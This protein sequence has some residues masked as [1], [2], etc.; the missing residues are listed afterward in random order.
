MKPMIS[1]FT[2]TFALS[3]SLLTA[4][5]PLPIAAD[6]LKEKVE[7]L[8]DPAREGRAT[9]EPGAQ[10]SAEW[11][12]KYLADNGLLPVNSGSFQD[13][14]FN[15]G[16][17]LVSEK[18]FFEIAGNS[19]RFE[20]DKDFRPLSYSD[21][22]TVEGEVVFAGYGL[23]APEEQGARRY[24]SYEGVDVKDKIVL[25]LR[26]VPE[27]LEPARRAQLNRYAG[28]RYKAMLARSR[29]A[30]A[31]LVV[32]GP[33][34]PLP[35]ELLPLANDG[36]LSGSN[37]LAASISGST[38]DALLNPSGKSLKDLQTA[39]DSEN[40]HAEQ[41]FVIPDLHVKLDVELERI[42][43]TDRN[44]LAA[45]PPV[46]TDE[47][48][49]V[50][51]HYDHLGHGSG[52]NSLAHAEEHD[53]IHP[54]ADDN[55][56][57][58]ALVMELAS[59]LSHQFASDSTTPRRG[60]LFALWSGEEMGLLGS[61][62]FAKNPPIPLDKIAAYVNFDMV[63]R[64]RDNRLMLQGA[65][66][67]PA[68][69]KLIEKRNVAAGFNLSIQDDPY[70]PTDVTSFYQH[71]IPV[72]NFFTGAHEDYHRPTDTSDKLDYAGLERIGSFARQIVQDLATTTERPEYVK[73]ERSSQP[74]GS[75]ENLR[76]YLGTIPDYTTDATGVK[77][78]GTRGGSP[79]EKAGFI[80]GDVIV[81]FAGQKIA[82]IYDYT[83]AL[84]AVKI[85]QEIQV[86]IER[87][88]ERMNL[89][90]TPEAR[91]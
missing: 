28:M 26:Y 67:S 69:R 65:G 76:A 59:A 89:A 24:D 39:L 71:N 42:T 46:G 19:A 56:S 29:G 21:N 79:A 15:A 51:A 10:A 41:G 61:A 36:S 33:N 47:W 37:I 86:I 38:A 70:L 91:K 12:A 90:V 45:I 73:V 49:I 63:G 77:I 5:V 13:F 1:L 22:G 57:G 16:V 27:E 72:I 17:K 52:G 83:Y 32:S 58:T 4:K 8:A 64:L 9:G 82:N 3:L 84:D 53:K 85:G 55:A 62:A 80:G 68:W 30:K 81:E 34:S 14:D 60:L 40:P 50:G 66:S 35:G 88:G 31:V 23:V 43:R 48:I 74:G 20:I 6:T 78:S 87:D 7:W 75:R 54:G 44:V 11:I 2:L 18:N 25:V